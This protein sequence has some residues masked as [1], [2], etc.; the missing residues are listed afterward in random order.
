[1]LSSHLHPP[2]F[3]FKFD[4]LE[5]ECTH[6]LL[7]DDYYTKFYRLSERDSVSLHVP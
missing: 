1:M 5:R 3:P 7:V 4:L 6:F 2:F